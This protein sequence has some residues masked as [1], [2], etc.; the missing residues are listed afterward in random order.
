[1]GFYPRY[2]GFPSDTFPNYIYRAEDSLSRGPKNAFFVTWFLWPLQLGSVKL[3][4]KCWKVGNVQHGPV[5]GFRNLQKTTKMLKDF[6]IL[7]AIWWIWKGPFRCLTQ[8]WLLS[9]AKLFAHRFPH[10]YHISIATKSKLVTCC[11]YIPFKKKSRKNPHV[12]WWNHRLRRDEMIIPLRMMFEATWWKSMAFSRF[13]S[14]KYPYVFFMNFK[15]LH[16]FHGSS[17]DA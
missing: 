1:M 14:P 5:S 16:I 10:I 11:F 3:T 4:Y 12:W 9:K 2:W 8:I 17:H 6:T 7:M 13:T 15:H